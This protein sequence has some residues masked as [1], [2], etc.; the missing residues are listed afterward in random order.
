MLGDSRTKPME[1]LLVEDGLMDA[2]VTIHALRSSGVHH[3]VTLCRNVAETMKFLRREGV[4]ARAP[5][6]DLLLLD[7]M[8]PDGTGID[9][10]EMLPEIPKNR[11]GLTTVVLT[12][13]DDPALKARCEELQVNDYIA[14]PV[15]E[16]EFLRVVRNQKTL[17]VHSTPTL[18][19]V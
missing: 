11:L 16:A 9:I 3:R 14:K 1:I 4:F 5:T 2:R 15:S 13:A 12:A 10:L 17:M 19:S 18:A 6:P 7:M 8:L